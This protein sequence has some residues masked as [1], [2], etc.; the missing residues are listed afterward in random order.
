MPIRGITT[1]SGRAPC[2]TLAR[3]AAACRLRLL[4]TLAS[5]SAENSINDPAP[6]VQQSQQQSEG[7]SFTPFTLAQQQQQQRQRQQQQRLDAQ[8]HE[9]QRASY[10]GYS[11]V[12]EQK[13]P[14]QFKDM[15]ELRDYLHR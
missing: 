5:G 6:E 11:R 10:G 9:R 14:S 1:C 3:G 2:S 7:T 8:R 15:D 13:D 12:R 4:H